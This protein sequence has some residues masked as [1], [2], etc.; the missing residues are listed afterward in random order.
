[1]S[2]KF[3]VKIRCMNPDCGHTY[4]RIMEADDTDAL[5]VIPDPPCPKCSVTAKK[6]KFDFASGKAPGV[7]G[8]LMVRAVD[9]TLNTVAEDYGMTD[10][11]T[12]VRE[13]EAMAPKLP[14]KQQAMADNFFAKP[15]NARQQRGGIFDMSPRAV[16]QAAVSGRFQTQDTVDPVARQHQKRDAPPVHIIAGDGVRKN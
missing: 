10:L 16:M 6:K 7:G 1:M 13:G 9:T 15:K 14:P 4:K 12:D 8:S 2:T 3:Q 5:A 11:R